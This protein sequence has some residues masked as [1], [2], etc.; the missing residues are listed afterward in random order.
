M[1]TFTLV[2]SKTVTMKNV[3]MATSLGLDGSMEARILY[4][5]PTSDIAGAEQKLKDSLAGGGDDETEVRQDGDSTIV[6]VKIRGKDQDEFNQRLGSY[7]NGSKITVTREGGYHPFGSD[8]TVR[9]E[10]NPASKMGSSYYQVP[11]EFTVNGGEL[12]MKSDR[13]VFAT[14]DLQIP[15]SGL[16][17]TDLIVN[18]II[19]ALV[20]AGLILLFLFRKK[21]A[22]ARAKGRER[23]E[24]TAAA[25]AATAP[26]AAGAAGAAYGAAQ[27]YAAPAQ[28]APAQDAYQQQAAYPAQGGYQPQQGAAY[29][30]GDDSPTQVFSPQTVAQPGAAQPGAAQSGAAQPVQGEADPTVAMP[31]Q[32]PAQDAPQQPAQPQYGQQQPAQPTQFGD[33]DGDVLQ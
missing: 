13:G 2:S 1:P 10:V 16:S 12:S 5:F 23:R 33:T 28:G 24:A 19:L 8:Y 31:A 25:Y 20:L 9:P 26:A 7:L 15:A 21:I 18:G 17:M 4:S 11:F 6:S 32:A 30:A 14:R 3:K 29:A 22:A 27:G